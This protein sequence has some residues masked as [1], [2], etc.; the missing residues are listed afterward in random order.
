MDQDQKL[1]AVHLG[2]HSGQKG[3]SRSPLALWVLQCTRIDGRDP[4]EFNGSPSTLMLFVT[5]FVITTSSVLIM[6]FYGC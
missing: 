6:C 1:A 4:L 2:F 3:A 5:H